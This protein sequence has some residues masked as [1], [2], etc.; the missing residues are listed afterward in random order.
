MNSKASGV[1]LTGKSRT[2]VGRTPYLSKIRCARSWYLTEVTPL[3]RRGRA[4]SQSNSASVSTTTTSIGVCSAGQSIVL[5]V[6][7]SSMPQQYGS[8]ACGCSDCDS[9]GSGQRKRSVEAPRVTKNIHDGNRPITLQPQLCHIP[10]PT[11]VAKLAASCVKE[12]NIPPQQ[13]IFQT[14]PEP[15]RGQTRISAV[16]IFPEAVAP[17][18][19]PCVAS[20]SCTYS[21]VLGSAAY[22]CAW[23]A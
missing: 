16:K 10:S 22:H 1:L 17:P 15:H 4:A 11:H 18:V 6:L 20:T 8:T 5:Q 14:L 21:R 9:S 7:G 23:F 19:P 12:L 3:A 13:R 2:K